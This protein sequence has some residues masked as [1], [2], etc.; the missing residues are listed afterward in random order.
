MMRFDAMRCDGSRGGETQRRAF[1]SERM[2]AAAR[3]GVLVCGRP[4]LAEDGWMGFSSA[5]G[6]IREVVR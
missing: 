4:L 1:R 2:A 5:D 6:S 3:V